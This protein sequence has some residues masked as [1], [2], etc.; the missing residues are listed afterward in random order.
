MKGASFVADAGAV[1]HTHSK[2]A[3][4]IT[5]LC[6]GPEFVITLQEM[7]KGIKNQAAGKYLRYDDE[8]VVP[9][10]EN[11]CHEADLKVS[12]LTVRYLVAGKR[13]IE[14][15]RTIWRMS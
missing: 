14:F 9:I 1:I 13:D 12:V 4:L 8:L 5:I 3:N 6:P 10:I 11:T 7:I 15:Y 2:W